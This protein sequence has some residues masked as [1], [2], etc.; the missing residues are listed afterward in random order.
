MKSL[1]EALLTTKVKDS[2]DVDDLL[3][4]LFTNESTHPLT[5]V[6]ENGWKVVETSD[7]MYT[8]FYV[9]QQ[10]DQNTDLLKPLVRIFGTYGTFYE[11][12]NTHVKRVFSIAL[13]LLQVLENCPEISEQNKL[14]NNIVYLVN[15]LNNTSQTKLT[16]QCDSD[17]QL[18]SQP[19]NKGPLHTYAMLDAPSLNGI[20]IRDNETVYKFPDNV[21]D[22]LKD[23][24][25]KVVI[26]KHLFAVALQQ[27][28][29][30][31]GG[32]DPSQPGVKTL[33][34][35]DIHDMEDYGDTVSAIL[36]GKKML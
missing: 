35:K 26:L 24:N 15:L 7:K 18:E 6:Y 30:G 1:T 4:K 10:P 9:E 13:T 32:G 33:I 31:V 36:H 19:V 25:T 16:M 21:K 28:L 17:L 2:V 29:N 27:M 14:F 34:P 20:A 12:S 22:E 8:G 5:V 23:H 3:N 11:M